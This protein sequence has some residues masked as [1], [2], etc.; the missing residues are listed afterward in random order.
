MNPII[1]LYVTLQTFV[2]DRVER[3][4]RSSDRGAEAIEYA[5][6]IIIAAAV[7]GFVYAAI[8]GINI[9]Q[10]VADALNSVF[11]RPQQ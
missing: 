10:K 4:R 2:V 1:P 5:A 3:L 8:S 11:N 9:Q 7:I 6:L